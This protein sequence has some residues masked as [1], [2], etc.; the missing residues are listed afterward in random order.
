MTP[1][2]VATFELQGRTFQ[3]VNPTARNLRLAG[4]TVPGLRPGNADQWTMHAEI[5]AMF[6]AYEAGLQGGEAVL[7]VEGIEV[8]PWCRG[9]I[10]TLARLLSLRRLTV[11]DASGSLTVFETPKN[12]LP[13]KLGGKAWN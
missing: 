11:R 6:Q 2:V 13:V 5:G 12:L 3:D 10:K 7:T 4:P 9:D 8:C 1:D